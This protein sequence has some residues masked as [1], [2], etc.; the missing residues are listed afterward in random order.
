MVLCAT[1]LAALAGASVVKGSFP[2]H[3]GIIAV[4]FDEQCIVMMQP[5]GK[6]K[7]DLPCGGRGAAPDW[8]P[9][10]RRLLFVGPLGEPGV[11][12]AD[13]SHQRSVRLGATPPFSSGYK[14]SFAPDR[15]H[16]AYTRYQPDPAG[17]HPEIWRA[18][19][20]G[21]GDRLLRPGWLPRWSPKGG[22][23]A[24]VSPEGG[25]WLMNAR[26]GRRIRRIGVT[27]YSLDWSPD[28]RWIVYS[29]GAVGSLGY[30]RQRQGRAAPPCLVRTRS[31]R[32]CRVVA[33]RATDRDCSTASPGPRVL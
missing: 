3:N 26:T 10:G 18:S 12:G 2:G 4:G 28:G 6:A 17:A 13:G 15:R 31:S 22:R 27:A 14:P 9:S 1:A 8:S 25:T 5:G 16:F 11:M 21:K 24:Y 30:A 19:I 32:R 23:I 33:E 29:S 20:D 7:R